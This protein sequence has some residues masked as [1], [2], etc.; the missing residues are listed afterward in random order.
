[1]AEDTGPWTDDVLRRLARKRV[2]LP[3]VVAELE[4]DELRRRGNRVVLGIMGLEVLVLGILLAAMGVF[5]GAGDAGPEAELW[6]AVILL[7]VP[8]LTGLLLRFILRTR[9]RRRP[10][11]ADHPWR[12]HVT[13]EGMEVLS[14][15]GR[16]LAG[17]WSSWTYR[18][19]GIEGVRQGCM[20]V[21][22]QLACEGDEI[23]IEF[24][25]FRR[26]DAM[27]LVPGVLQG[28]ARVGHTDR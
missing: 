17:P 12:F 1:M 9:D 13:A 25:R 21:S 14:A 19:H 26:S 4:N 2:A 16:R 10:D 18:S 8:L 28:L 22:L 6:L 5:P 27:Q 11:E 3:V 20:A 23:S 24:S 15:Q 7:A